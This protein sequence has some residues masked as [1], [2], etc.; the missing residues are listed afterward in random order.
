MRV[1]FSFISV[2]PKQET[3][4]QRN[5]YA[6]E[7]DSEEL[8][9]DEDDYLANA[10]DQASDKLA[11]EVPDTYAAGLKVDEEAKF[12]TTS[13]LF[14]DLR[15]MAQALQPTK[16]EDQSDDEVNLVSHTVHV[17]YRVLMPPVVPKLR[18]ERI[19]RFESFRQR[20]HGFS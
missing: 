8:D 9:Y 14:S 3:T 5:T 17:G 11:V 1:A 4:Q 7:S 19:K 16:V 20:S 2:P 10:K 18:K 13:C 12:D 6:L 15:A